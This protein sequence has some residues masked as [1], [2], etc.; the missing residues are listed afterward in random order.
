MAVTL[1]EIAKVSQSPLQKGILLN[2]LRFSPLLDV[3]PFEPADALDNIVVRWKTLPSVASRKINAGYD[4]STGDTEQVTES[5]RPMGGDIDVDKVLE[6]LPNVLEKPSVTQINM[7]TKAMAFYFNYLF[8]KGSVAVDPDAFYGL[9]Y[10]VSQLPARQKFAI[11]SAGTPFDCTASTA[12]EHAFVDALHEMDDLVGGASAFFCNRKM[13]LGV[14]R[15]LR[16]LG[17]LDTTK[18]QF[19]RTVYTF[20]GAPIIDAGLKADKSTEIITDTEDPGDGGNDTTSIYAVHFGQPEG[21]VGVQLNDLD[22]YLVTN[23]LESKPSK[24]WRIDW[25]VGL[26]G[27]GD[28]YATRMYNLE[29]A[30]SWT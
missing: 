30:T 7:K 11:G 13:R 20:N 8:I 10:R 18:D 24:R 19:E 6:S 29:P 1:S 25:V 21:L 4:E 9:E 16:R 15:V 12:N 26:A 3:V 14:G 28:Y 2:L 5:I 17:L 22:A 23:E 27:F